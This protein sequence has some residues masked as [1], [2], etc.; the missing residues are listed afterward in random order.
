V[1]DSSFVLGSVPNSELAV[2]A[3]IYTDHFSGPGRAIGPAYVCVSVCPN[4]RF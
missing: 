1:Y 4:K 3:G 2:V